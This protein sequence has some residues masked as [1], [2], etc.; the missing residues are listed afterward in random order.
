MP[1]ADSLIIFVWCFTIQLHHIHHPAIP[2]YCSPSLRNLLHAI[3]LLPFPPS[4]TFISFSYLPPNALP[5]LPK[6]CILNFYLTDQ[7]NTSRLPLK[8]LF[9]F[10]LLLYLFPFFFSLFDFLFFL[11]CL[12]SIFPINILLFLS[13]ALVSCPPGVTMWQ[14]KTG[15]SRARQVNRL[16]SAGEAWRIIQCVCTGRWARKCVCVCVC[17]LKFGTSSQSY[18]SKVAPSVAVI[19]RSV[20]CHFLSC[21]YQPSLFLFVSDRSLIVFY[22]FYFYLRSFPV[23]RQWFVTTS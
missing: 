6:D 7:S 8:K 1:S 11:S 16:K 12:F 21:P 4:C 13:P 5:V 23:L 15:W 22:F 9:A 20:C 19:F 2:S 10:S 18:V 17:V 3:L 14:G